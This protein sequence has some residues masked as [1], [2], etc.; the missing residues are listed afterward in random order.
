MR[1]RA[2]LTSPVRVCLLFRRHAARVTGTFLGK[3]KSGELA[4]EVAA[5]LARETAAAIPYLTLADATRAPATRA[6]IEAVAPLARGESPHLL[7][8]IDSL[9]SWTEAQ[10]TGANEYEALGHGMAALRA[11]AGELNCAILAICER[12]RASAGKGGLSASA[13]SRKAEYGSE[14]VISLISEDRT[15]LG[16]TP[17]TLKLEK[18]RNGAPGRTFELVF[19]GPI[20]TFREGR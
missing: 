9:H 10:E 13:G 11:I 5:R 8:V 7:I 14:T 18:N 4:P 1:P 20:Q 19:D 6:W 12:N 2:Q 15:P 17:I 3:F 16:L